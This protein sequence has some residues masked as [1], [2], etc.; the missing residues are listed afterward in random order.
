MDFE[1]IVLTVMGLL[2]IIIGI[3]GF[4]DFEKFFK[5]YCEFMDARNSLNIDYPK[6]T[7]AKVVLKL[8]LGMCLIMGLTIFVC[9]N[10]SS[11]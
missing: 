8:T 3:Y 9:N 10:L 1:R 11:N 6:G 7:Y 4:L 2:F 5:Q